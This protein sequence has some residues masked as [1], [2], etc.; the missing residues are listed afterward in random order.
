[1]TVEKLNKMDAFRSLLPEPGGEVVGELIA[2]LRKAKDLLE[3]ACGIIANAG[4]P[5]GDWSSMTPEWRAAAVRWREDWFIT[6]RNAEETSKP[7]QCGSLANTIEAKPMHRLEEIVT[8]KELRRD[9]DAIIQRVKACPSTRERSIVVTKL[10]EGVMWLG[11]D[12][13][14]I[15]E[16]NPGAVENPYPNSKDPSNLKIEPTADGL[17]L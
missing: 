6:L 12:L 3:T 9:I 13:K 5:H 1:M 16:G 17:K 15:N 4:V 7:R 14:R 2:E 8:D 10:Q 11:M